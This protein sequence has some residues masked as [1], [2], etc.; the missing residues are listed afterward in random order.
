MEG[1]ALPDAGAG[2]RVEGEDD[3]DEEDEVLNPEKQEV[4][5]E[6][7]QK[8]KAQRAKRK[9]DDL[10][11]SIQ[12]GGKRVALN[13]RYHI[14]LLS[15]ANGRVM[16]RRYENG[17]YADLQKNLIQWEDDLKMCND[18]SPSARKVR[19]EIGEQGK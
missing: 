2:A 14:L 17:N 6:E 1:E 15:G 3:E 18:M 16:V 19:I 5:Y 4:L 11:K 8:T 9:A 10:I 7:E 12:D 13:C